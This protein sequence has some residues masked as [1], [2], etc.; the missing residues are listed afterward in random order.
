[1]DARKKDKERVD[2][3]ER[4]GKTNRVHRNKKDRETLNVEAIKSATKW[5]QKKKR[6]KKC[7]FEDEKGKLLNWKGPSVKFVVPNL[8]T[9]EISLELNKSWKY[10]T[11]YFNL[12]F[13]LKC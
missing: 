8:V 13:I 7:Y 10:V 11:N 3:N 6:N 2:W 4:K 1:M 5:K 12:I 9:P